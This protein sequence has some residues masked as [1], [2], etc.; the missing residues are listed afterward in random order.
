MD[1]LYGFG[2]AL[3]ERMRAARARRE[4]GGGVRLCVY[5]AILDRDRDY[6]PREEKRK[7]KRLTM[8]TRRTLHRIREHR[9]IR[10]PLPRDVGN[11]AA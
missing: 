9:F 3:T 10:E 7:K 4:G 5:V 11:R 6:V 1:S 8:E 2:A